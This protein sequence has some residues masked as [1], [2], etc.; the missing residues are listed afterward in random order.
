MSKVFRQLKAVASQIAKL[1]S[2]EQVEQ[3]QKKVAINAIAQLEHALKTSNKQQLSKA[4]NSLAKAF[5]VLAGK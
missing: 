5:V 3:D 2:S 4:V 1:Q